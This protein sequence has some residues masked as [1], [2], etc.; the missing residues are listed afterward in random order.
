[1]KLVYICSPYRGDK[2]KNTERVRQYCRMAD[3]YSC[4]PIAPHLFF[5]T[6]LNDDSF[7][8]RTSGMLMGLELLKYCSEVWIFCNELSE[9][10]IQ[11]IKKARELNIPLKFYN[12]EMEEINHDNYLIHTEIGP[13]YRKLIADTFG[14]FYAFD[15]CSCSTC[16]YRTEGSSTEGDGKEEGIKVRDVIDT[17]S[18]EGDGKPERRNF[19]RIRFGRRV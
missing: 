16:R 1:M 11:E 13:A 15:G 19:L 6:Y 12:T 4:L 9:G 14:D 17:G 8:D 7:M 18:T 2:E 5:T 10:M 3:I